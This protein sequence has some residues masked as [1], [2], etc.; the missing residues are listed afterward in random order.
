[1]PRVTG[2]A[3]VVHAYVCAC[4][5]WFIHVWHDSFTCDLSPSSV[6][7]L[8][9]LRHVSFIYAMSHKSCITCIR[10]CMR[11]SQT[12]QSRV[13][14]LIHVWHDSFMC[15]MTHLSVPWLRSHVWLLYAYV[16]MRLA[17]H[18]NA[19]CHKYGYAM[20]IHMMRH[21]RATWCMHIYV[22]T[23]EHVW[24]ET[25]WHN[26]FICGMTHS[27]VAFII[28]HGIRMYTYERVMSDSCMRYG[29]SASRDICYDVSR[30]TYS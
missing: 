3:G 15:D 27:S 8:I 9:H 13:T 12:T 18:M 29:T 2:H 26:S 30:C 4:L 23:R 5:T 19:A 6:T 7:W 21:V 16:C 20:R 28:H 25:V 1:M 14:W 17:P 10:T 22:I 24:Q 11:K